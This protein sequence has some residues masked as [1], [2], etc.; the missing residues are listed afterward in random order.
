VLCAA[1]LEP[2]G[3]AS[4]ALCAVSFWYVPGAHSTHVLSDPWWKPALQLQSEA[5][6]LDAPDW[7][8]G[9]QGKHSM[10]FTASEYVPSVQ[11]THK[12]CALPGSALYFPLSHDWHIESCM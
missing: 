2:T 1:E 11:D 9:V 12:F 7:E 3:H 5:D 4:Q 6:V 8:L 10:E